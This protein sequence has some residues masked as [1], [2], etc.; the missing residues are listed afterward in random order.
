VIID[1]VVLE[2]VWQ[3]LDAARTYH[4]A[5]DVRTQAKNIGGTHRPSNLTRRLETAQE[6]LDAAFAEEEQSELPEE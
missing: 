3:A 4:V 6:A 1:R 5:D 2:Q